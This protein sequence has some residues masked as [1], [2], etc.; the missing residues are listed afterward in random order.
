[1]RRALTTAL[2]IV[3]MASLSLPRA[4]AQ[5]GAMVDRALESMSPAARGEVDVILDERGIT[6]D[7]VRNNPA[8]AM[9]LMRS[10]EIQA[11]IK[12]AMEGRVAGED[13]KTRVDQPKPEREQAPQE[14]ARES[15]G[16][17]ERRSPGLPDEY[18]VIVDGNVFRKLGWQEPEKRNPFRLAGVVG[19]P[20]GAR[21][22]IVKEG[23]AA[24]LYVEVGADVGDGYTVESIDGLSVTLAG[25]ALGEVTLQLDPDVVG[26]RGGG[27]E[28]QKKDRG[29]APAKDDGGRW[30]PKRGMEFMQIVGE[31][32]KRENL[33]M[34]DVENDEYL[35]DT[36]RTKYQYLE[37]EG[38]TKF[39]D[40]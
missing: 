26:S 10:P 25:G 28:R 29:P 39:P 2:V 12:R 38:Y 36:L 23:R 6:L 32:L 37:D 21:V 14:R 35:Q 13:P 18:K 31:I 7:D 27:G 3:A 22:L 1:M 15:G 20:S 16:P 8:L 9:E 34:Q 4:T 33:T 19:R 24:G 40:D 17:R 11:R 5:V 30:Y